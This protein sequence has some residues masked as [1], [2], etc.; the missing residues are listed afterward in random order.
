MTLAVIVVVP[1]KSS[2]RQFSLPKTQFIIIETARV[3]AY[4]RA[5]YYA[6]VFFFSF[7]QLSVLR[8]VEAALEL[9]CHIKD[10]AH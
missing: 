9:H 3:S 8:L 5:M 7:V 4:A 10:P 2:R 1:K 6:G